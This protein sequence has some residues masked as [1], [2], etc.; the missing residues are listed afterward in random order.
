MKV[1]ERYPI[2]IIGL[3]L[4]GFMLLFIPVSSSIW[5]IS[6]DYTL[7]TVIIGS[8]LLGILSG[9]LGSFS[10]LRNQSLLGDAISHAALPG[11]AIAFLVAGKAL[12]ALLFGA[13]ISGWVG[14]LFLRWI[15]NTSRLKQDAILGIILTSWFAMGIVLLTYIQSRAD[16]SQAGL[17]SFIFG[18]AAAIVASDVE[19]I[20]VVGGVMLVILTLFWKQFKLI[21]FDMGFA[22]ANGFNTSLIDIALST[23]IVMAIVLG[24]QIAGVILMVGLLIAPSVAARQWTHKLGEMVFLAAIFGA[25]A[26]TLGAVISAVDVNLPTGPLIIIV[27]SGIVLISLLFAPA[28]GLI[29]HWLEKRAD[30]R[31]FAGQYVINDM[32]AY[33]QSHGGDL[34]YAVP[35]SFIMGLHGGTAKRGIQLLSKMG[36]IQETS[37]QNLQL[38]LAGQEILRA[39]LRNQQLWHLYREVGDALEMPKIN[40]DLNEDIQSKLPVPVIHQL[41][42]LLKDGV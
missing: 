20:A 41:E 26:G 39:K 13:F 17:E 8:A 5:N 27:A 29:W 15:G 21:T 37:Q 6:Y 4:L 14:V 42:N 28:R 31:Q 16:A 9:V 33:I 34:D 12:G 11:V 10:M 38:T 24:L 19:L 1:I 30:Q 2:V 35:K 23:M 40:I 3:V 32:Y 18:Q 7:N 25:F 36:Y 22:A